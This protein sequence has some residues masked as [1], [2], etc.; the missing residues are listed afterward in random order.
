MDEIR[1]E[2]PNATWGNLLTGIG[3]L[4]LIAVFSI[5]YF[6]KTPEEQ[7]NVFTDLLSRDEIVVE[8]EEMAEGVVVVE[9]GEGIW[10]VAER[11]CGDGEKYNKIAHDNNLTI[12]S[13]V[14][15]GQELM[16]TC[17]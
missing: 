13:Y 8:E 12:W 4:I 15:P 9:E 6:G 3:I 16:V 5:W 10:H 11:V 1:R 2:N 7:E 17:E 14:T